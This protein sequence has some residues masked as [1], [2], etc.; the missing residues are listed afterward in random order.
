MLGH[1]YCIL[2]RLSSEVGWNLF[3][4]IRELEKKRKDK[5][6]LV[7]ER[8]KHLNNLRVKAEKV[9]EDKLGSQL[10]ILAP[11]TEQS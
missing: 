11:D 10:D 4:I 7:Y 8:K 5:A 3:D 9:A 6:Q 1:K 2:G